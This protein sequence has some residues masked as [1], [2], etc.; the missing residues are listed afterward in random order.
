[1]VN[2]TLK[3][4]VFESFPLFKHDIPTKYCIPGV[5]DVCRI[6]ASESRPT[7]STNIQSTTDL[8]LNGHAPKWMSLQLVS[9]SLFW[10][11]IFWRTQCLVNARV[12]NNDR[13][14]KK[15]DFKLTIVRNGI[16]IVVFLIISQITIVISSVELCLSSRSRPYNF[17]S[18]NIRSEWY[19]ILTVL[20][21][22]PRYG[23]LASSQARPFSEDDDIIWL[24][25]WM[26][27]SECMKEGMQ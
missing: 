7:C 18:T 10:R 14:Q 3:I 5:G 2:C 13:N 21:I 1:M 25:Q 4:I 8:A 20:R 23:W 12:I 11:G 6:R 15:I 27:C 22:R 17:N 16:W 19:R 9:V 24:H 26:S